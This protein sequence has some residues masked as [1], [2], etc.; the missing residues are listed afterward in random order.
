MINSLSE[1]DAQ[2]FN[3]QISLYSLFVSASIKTIGAPLMEIRNPKYILLY[4]CGSHT[5]IGPGARLSQ[6]A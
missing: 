1:V 4:R 5:T 3:P 2:S 6:R